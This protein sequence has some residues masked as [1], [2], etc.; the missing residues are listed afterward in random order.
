MPRK[1]TDFEQRDR[2]VASSG[3]QSGHSRTTFPPSTGNFAR[4]A[5]SR[6]KGGFIHSTPELSHPWDRASS[7]A[8]QKAGQRAFL[9]EAKA[10]R[11]GAE[12][13]KADKA[14]RKRAGRNW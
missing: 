11:S 3:A 10:S 7:S 4:T 12:Q 13:P 8:V 1:E 14:R 2:K 6:V 5:R 9:A